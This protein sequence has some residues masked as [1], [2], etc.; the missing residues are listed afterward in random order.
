MANTLQVKRSGT[1]DAVPS[2]LAE[3]EL[4]ANVDAAT[5]VGNLWLGIEGGAEIKILTENQNTLVGFGVFVDTDSM[6][7]NSALRVPSQQSVKAYVD[8]GTVTMTNKRVTKRRTAVASSTTPTP[9]CDDEDF[10]ELTALAVN[11]TF[12]AI[13]G[14][15]TDGQPMYIRIEDN[16]TTRTLAF[17]SGT[18]GYRAIGVTLPTATTA[19]KLIYLALVYHATDDKW[20]VIGVSEEA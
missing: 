7:E 8:S 1:A 17:N 3:G 14:T 13:T 16:G 15:G 10:Y 20:D 12:G 4:G 5:V 18:G 6:S 2:S 11:A 9:D 19:N